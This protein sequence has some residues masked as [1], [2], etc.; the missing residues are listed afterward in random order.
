MFVF[1][2]IRPTKHHFDCHTNAF[3]LI[4]LGNYSNATVP[5]PDF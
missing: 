3:D 5:I 4:S 2:E 1:N